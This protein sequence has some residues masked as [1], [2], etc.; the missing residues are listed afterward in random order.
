MSGTRLAVILKNLRVR[1]VIGAL[2]TREIEE[3]WRSQFRREQTALKKRDIFYFLTVIYGCPVA[4]GIP[5]SSAGRYPGIGK[6]ISVTHTQRK[7]V[8]WDASQL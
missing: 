1:R 3:I 6:L 2:L 4:I 7:N 8:V 5:E